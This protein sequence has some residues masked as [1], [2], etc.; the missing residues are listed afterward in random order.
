ML[1]SREKSRVKHEQG[2][3]AL[4][5]TASDES[6]GDL[7]D[8]A[9][10][11]DGAVAR[12]TQADRTAILLR[13]TRIARSSK[14]LPLSVS[15]KRRHASASPRGDDRLRKLL[16]AYMPDAD[17]LSATAALGLGLAPVHLTQT[18]TTIAGW[19]QSRQRISRSLLP[20][21]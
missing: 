5:Q 16:G 1:R 14:S 20:L 17:G 19:K 18:L 7:T 11:L 2:A 8:L 12:L 6:R 4:R 21:P 13:S 9:M 10:Q 3:A 15:A